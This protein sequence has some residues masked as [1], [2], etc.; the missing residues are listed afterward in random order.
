MWS[1]SV[2]MEIE[3]LFLEPTI[4]RKLQ[5]IESSIQGALTGQLCQIP[6]I[7]GRG[8]A[9]VLSA[10]LHP[11]KKGLGSLEG[12]AR[13]M[14]DLA[15]IELQAMELGLRTLFEFPEAPPELKA[16]LAELTLS[17]ARHLQLCID[18]LHDLGFKWGH[19]PIHTAL[20]QAVSPND[21]LQDRMLIVHRYLEGSGLDA[22]DTILRRLEGVGDRRTFAILKQIHREEI[23]HVYFGSRWYKN[24]MEDS[25]VGGVRNSALEL[26]ARLTRLRLQLPKRI[27]PV[28]HKWRLQAGFTPEEI[29]VLEEF[30]LTW[31]SIP[32]GGLRN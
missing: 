10:N 30:R 25:F 13:L 4:R 15:N 7:P 12:R 17:E 22:Q 6:E 24:L 2:I 28:C 9:A 14:H 32:Q 8:T 27:E 18:G 3:N 16:E 31:L 5:T 1:K 20:W 11:P 23:D 29:E 19:W 26:K 21:S